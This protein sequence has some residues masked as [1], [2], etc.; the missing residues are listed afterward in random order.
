M[1][2]LFL[3]AV[4]SWGMIFMFNTLSRNPAKPVKII[5]DAQAAKLK[6]MMQPKH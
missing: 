1:R 6:D 5:S 2:M 3:I 4:T